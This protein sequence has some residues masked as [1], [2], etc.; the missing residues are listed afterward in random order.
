MRSL[1]IFVA[2]VALLVGLWLYWA[3]HSDVI[4]VW[5]THSTSDEAIQRAGSWGD[6]FG[7]FNALVS[8]FGSAAILATLWLQ[9]RSVKEQAADLHRQR[10]ESAYFELLRL[11]RDARDAVT[12]R[13][14]KEY[15]EQRELEAST[16]NSFRTLRNSQTRRGYAAIQSA[17]QELR[18]WLA[19]GRDKSRGSEVVRV[20][21]EKN[22]HSSNE[23]GLGPYFRIIYT[24]LN[25]TRNDKILSAAEKASY[26]NILR[27]Q[28][29]SEEITILAVN[30]L[31]PF[32]NDLN[33]LIVEFR[34]LKYLPESSMKRRLHR[35]Y[36][37][38]AFLSRD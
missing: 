38:A 5:W 23:S 9:A 25:K 8:A 37:A 19:P 29:T 28:L 35:I 24:I 1:G 15:T 21:Y 4:S 14:S 27:S 3:G 10:F 26:G 22:I 6:S 34:M 17:V 20:V 31:A 11:L 33:D 7:A 32:A 12:F 13:H 2:A 18:Y 30:A 16:R 36:G